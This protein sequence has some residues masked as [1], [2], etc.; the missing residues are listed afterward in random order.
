MPE[1]K[2]KKKKVR[3]DVDLTRKT[4][5]SPSINIPVNPT[6]KTS[7]SIRVGGVA[8]QGFYGGVSGTTKTKGGVEVSANLSGYTSSGKFNPNTF[9]KVTIPIRGKKKNR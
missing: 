1:D 6:K 9:F 4:K 2:K 8:G 7:G 5:P 3:T